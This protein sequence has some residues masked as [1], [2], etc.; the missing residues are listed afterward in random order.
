MPEVPAESRSK[1]RMIDRSD[2]DQ[3]RTCQGLQ[4]LRRSG[5]ALTSSPESPRRF[6]WNRAVGGCRP[7]DPQE[8]QLFK[9]CEDLSRKVDQATYFLSDNS[10]NDQVPA[11]VVSAKL[12]L[13]KQSAERTRDRTA[14]LV[15]KGAWVHAQTTAFVCDAQTMLDLLKEKYE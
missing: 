9:M 4:T 6:A 14:T 11:G 12:G 5:A 15:G 13:A 2:I 3:Q 7:V 8:T 1:P 10:E